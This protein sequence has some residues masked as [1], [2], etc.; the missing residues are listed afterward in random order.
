LYKLDQYQEYGEKAFGQHADVCF[1]WFTK[2]PHQKS[3]ASKPGEC[4]RRLALPTGLPQ[5][6]FKSDQGKSSAPIAEQ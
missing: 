2:N 4:Y 1:D 3:F 5:L 6:V